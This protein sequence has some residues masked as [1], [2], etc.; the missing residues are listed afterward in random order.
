MNQEYTRE[1]Y[2]STVTHL[3]QEIIGF[4]IR[5]A[6]EIVSYTLHQQVTCTG[7]TKPAVRCL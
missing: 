1:G 7:M 4:A 3:Q 6:A 5:T 2:I